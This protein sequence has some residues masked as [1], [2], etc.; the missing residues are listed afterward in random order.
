MDADR[1]IYR[2]TLVELARRDPRIY[3][4]DSDMGGLET[5]FGAQLPGQYVDLGIAE[6]NMMTVAAALAKVGKLPFVNTMAAFACARAYEQVKIDIAYHDLP[7]RIVAT[8]AGLSAAHYGPSHHAAQ[9]LA[10]MRALPNMT[11]ITPADPVETAKM[12]AA[13]AY[14]PGPVY[15]RMGCRPIGELIYQH[16]YAFTV[17]LA[18]ELRSGQDI[19][20]VAAGTY[21]LLAALEAADQLAA[22]GIAATV[23]N[24]HTIKPLDVAALV[25]AASRSRGVITVEDHSIIG[26]L[27]G[28]VAEALA[29]HCPT[30]VRRFGI[31]DL[32]YDYVGT[33]RELLETSGVTAARIV[34]AARDICR[35][36]RSPYIQPSLIN[37]HPVPYE[38][39]GKEPYHEPVS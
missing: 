27:G 9:D 38:K 12:I 6:A 33:H 8:H 18:V 7:V 28:A 25:A 15:I 30:H 32:F 11:V 1:A 39:T 5:C 4:V 16:D 26:G 29:E 14:H 22:L 20:I 21:P 23:L 10:A 31:Q 2:A 36:E 35:R 17:G 37:R 3:C 19:A 13:A 24:M 34:S